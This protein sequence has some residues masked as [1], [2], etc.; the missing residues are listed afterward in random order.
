MLVRVCEFQMGAVVC[1][2]T[3]AAA[4]E[5]VKSTYSTISRRRISLRKA[6]LNRLASN[7]NSVTV[8][9]TLN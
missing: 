8:T 3:S 4:F 1:R 6:D 5:R 7:C 2:E 9:F